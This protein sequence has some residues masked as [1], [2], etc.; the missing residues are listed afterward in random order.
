MSPVFIGILVYIGAAL[1]TGLLVSRKVHSESDYLI[2]G[3]QLGYLLTSFSIFATWFGAETCVGAAASVYD[4]GLSGGNADPFGYTICLLLMAWVFAAPMWKRKLTTLADLYRQRYS[5]SVERL[6]AIIIAPSSLIWAA[7]QIRA[8]GHV[9]SVSS[10]LQLETCILIATVIVLVYTVSGGLWA[11]AYTDVIQGIALIAGLGVLAF[12]IGAQEQTPSISTLMTNLW[13]GSGHAEPESWLSILDGWAVPIFGSIVA[14]ELI[15]R[16]IAARSATV[17]KRSAFL[18][19]AIYV[20]IGMI[21]VY[22]GLV[23]VSL[24]PGIEDSEQVMPK[25]ALTYLPTLLYVMYA[26]AL[27]SAILSTVD[28]ALLAASALIGHNVILSSRPNISEKQKLLV[29]RGG[30]LA[31]GVAAYFLAIYGTTTYAMVEMASGL[32]SAGIFVISLSALHSTRG[33]PIAAGA[34]LV[35]GLGISVWGSYISPFDG[36]YVASI[37]AAFVIYALISLREPGRA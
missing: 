14:Q 5:P 30:V 7:A 24:L 12:M 6:A 1:L 35:V 27:A 26:G 15:S 25:L 18:A 8:F 28:S 3:R 19:T 10:D 36:S 34:A 4:R 13:S 16:V 21:P 17:A 11:D 32:G 9:L 31:L 33:G 20:L 22:I 23:G 2:A 37:L 29:A